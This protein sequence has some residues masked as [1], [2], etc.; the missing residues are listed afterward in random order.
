[1]NQRAIVRV[2]GAAFGYEGRALLS[3]VDV[4]IH[5][6]TFLGIVGPNGSGKSTLIRGILGLL[7][8]MAGR[9]ERSGA[10]FGYVPQSRMLD[11]NYPLTVREVAEMGAGQRLTGLGRL[12]AE[13]QAECERY[14]EQVGMLATQDEAFSALSGG[15]RQRVLLARAMLTHPT[16]LLL[17]EPTSGVDRDAAASIAAIL[18]ELH[19]NGV[20]ILLV[21]HDLDF[22]RRVAQGLLVVS[23]GSVKF[24][25]LEDTHN[26]E[27]LREIFAPLAPSNPRR[28]AH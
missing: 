6:D 27:W 16:V 1:M 12:R 25:K 2:E 26:A 28:M 4:S 14:L 13:D 21:S 11:A 7:E 5:P 18:C 9:V 20:A 17:D 3:S 10:K 15:Q 22:V 8:P 19:H 23:R 24:A